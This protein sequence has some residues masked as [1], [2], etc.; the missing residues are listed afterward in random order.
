MVVQDAILSDGE[1]QAR[2][3]ISI[4]NIRLSST[5]IDSYKGFLSTFKML[6]LE[7]KYGFLE[8][9]G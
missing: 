2:P 7:S 1:Y 8:E 3:I 6:K 5:L 4:R 9:S